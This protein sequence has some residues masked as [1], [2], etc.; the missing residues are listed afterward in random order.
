MGIEVSLCKRLLYEFT[1][2]SRT[3]ANELFEPTVKCC[4]CGGGELMSYELEESI[5][6]YE[7]KCRNSD[8]RMV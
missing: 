8:Y 5:P 6:D 1:C 4:L 2:D 3:I 7:F